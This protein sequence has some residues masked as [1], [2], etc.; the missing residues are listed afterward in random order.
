MTMDTNKKIAAVI[1][2]HAFLLTI[3]LGLILRWSCG[4]SRACNWL[5]SRQHSVADFR[6]RGMETAQV[7]PTQQGLRRLSAQPLAPDRA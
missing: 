3:G 7:R 2:V 6:V 5:G 1:S 4:L